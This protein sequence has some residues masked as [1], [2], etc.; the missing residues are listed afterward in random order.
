MDQV[1]SI[2]WALQLSAAQCLAGGDED[3]KHIFSVNLIRPVVNTEKEI[4]DWVAGRGP[5]LDV[6]IVRENYGGFLFPWQ[7]QAT[8]W[9]LYKKVEGAQPWSYV[10]EVDLKSGLSREPIGDD[11]DIVRS[12]V[13]AEIEAKTEKSTRPFSAHPDDLK[14]DPTTGLRLSSLVLEIGPLTHQTAPVSNAILKLAGFVAVEGCD[15]GC[16]YVVFPEFI[17]NR[18]EAKI[19]VKPKEKEVPTDKH[20]GVWLEYEVTDQ[21]SGSAPADFPDTVI[22]IARSATAGTDP[23]FGDKAAAKARTD[24]SHPWRMAATLASAARLYSP[25]RVLANVVLQGLAI[26]GARAGNLLNCSDDVDS[27]DCRSIWR[28]RIAAML[29]MGWERKRKRLAAGVDSEEEVDQHVF[30][31]FASDSLLCAVFKKGE[32]SGSWNDVLD[33]DPFGKKGRKTFGDP[34]FFQEFQEFLTGSGESLQQLGLFSAF[35]DW[36]LERGIGVGHP[37]E[38]WLSQLASDETKPYEFLQS[39]AQ[40]VVAFTDDEARLDLQ[41]CWFAFLTKRFASFEQG[42]KNHRAIRM[43]VASLVKGCNE[44]LSWS[45]VLGTVQRSTYYDDSSCP[46]PMESLLAYGRGKSEEIACL[47]TWLQNAARAKLDLPD[48]I[49]GGSVPFKPN[50]KID[51]EASDRVGAL[52]R[53]IDQSNPDRPKPK[54]S[55]LQLRIDAGHADDGPAKED[56][57]LRGYAIAL[58][59]GIQYLDG[60]TKKYKWDDTRANWI[61]HT[62][63]RIDEIG[64][65]AGGA[66]YIRYNDDGKEELL[67]SSSPVGSTMSQG[68][69]LIEVPYDGLPIASLPERDGKVINLGGKHARDFDGK[70]AYDYRWVLPG[71]KLPLLGYGLVTWRQSTAIENAG[72]VCNEHCRGDGIA[73]LRPVGETHKGWDDVTPGGDGKPYLSLQLPGAPE[74]WNTDEEALKASIDQFDQTRAAT[75]LAEQSEAIGERLRSGTLAEGE[76][77]AVDKPSV[78]LINPG[79]EGYLSDLPDEHKFGV[80]APHCDAQFIQRWLNTDQLIL[81]YFGSDAAFR[82]ALLSHDAL[83]SFSASELET[84]VSDLVESYQNDKDDV[85][86]NELAIGFHPAVTALGLEVGLEGAGPPEYRVLRHKP[87][88]DKESG[89]KEGWVI[90]VTCGSSFAVPNETTLTGKSIK[91]EIPAGKFARVR[92][93]TLIEQKFFGGST[94]AS[95][96]DAKVGVDLNVQAAN[97][98]SERIEGVKYQAFGPLEYWFEVLPDTLPQDWLLEDDNLEVDTPETYRPYEAQLRLAAGPFDATWVR[99][100]EVE[101]HPAHWN[102]VPIRPPLRCNEVK[103]WLPLY[104]GTE[105]RV[106]EKVVKLVTDLRADGFLARERQSIG[107]PRKL[108]EQRPAGYVAYAARPVI[109]FQEWLDPERSKVRQLQSQTCLVGGLEQGICHFSP[110]KRMPVPVLKYA[111]PLTATYEAKGDDDLAGDSLPR[112]AGNGHLLVFDDSGIDPGAQEVYGGLGVHFEVDVLETRAVR[113]EAAEDVNDGTGERAETKYLQL[114]ELGLNPIHHRQQDLDEQMQVRIKSSALF[115]LTHDLVTNAKPAQTAI[116]ASITNSAYSCELADGGTDTEGNWYL[117]KIRVRRMLLPEAQLYGGLEKEK[118][119][120]DYRLPLRNAGGVLVPTDFALEFDSLDIDSVVTVNLAGGSYKFD[121]QNPDKLDTSRYLVSWHHGRF[122]KGRFSWRPQVLQ[123]RYDE[124]GREWITCNKAAPSHDWNIDDATTLKPASYRNEDVFMI[125]LAVNDKSSSLNCAQLVHLSDYSAPFWASFIGMFGR[126]K[127]G[128][129]DQY[130][131]RLS[132]QSLELIGEHLPK[133]SS[134]RCCVEALRKNLSSETAVEDFNPSFQLLHIFRP[135][136]YVDQGGVDTTGGEQVGVF[137]PMENDDC[138]AVP[139]FLNLETSGENID[140]RGCYAYLVS[141]QVASALS[142]SGNGSSELGRLSRIFNESEKPRNDSRWQDLLDEIFPSQDR[143]TPVNKKTPVESL[144][145][146]LPEILGS[147]RIVSD[148]Y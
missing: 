45:N 79:A 89:H 119:S 116:I 1:D 101:T 81:E 82:D 43:F 102:G 121:L 129:A 19:E 104:A 38:L 88:L 57:Y 29:G 53:A 136:V 66:R 5:K 83:S 145:R 141:Y 13:T 77:F 91:V 48:N 137:R 138:S 117:A 51:E 27:K 95:R 131:L 68:R 84:F 111:A 115:G 20:G 146:P 9:H 52:I 6:K 11:A 96:Y 100:I 18:D 80:N 10:D 127:L 120:N 26:T 144:I 65:G 47:K 112:R 114:A 21:D 54:D 93:Y 94:S 31:A 8:K 59:T 99:A 110:V 69:R 28:A 7:W 44:R 4:K 74:V 148:Q 75:W 62:A 15:E 42:E 97:G 40:L 132:G 50:E 143:K 46:N 64:E 32:C 125:S 122:D 33:V 55:G 61:T 22:F 36:R 107:R 126:S 98:F 24:V 25:D 85:P 130:E 90:E 123:Q 140:L 87:F 147:I 56:R 139:T 49:G 135:V 41:I 30:E 78:Y 142:V 105:T 2:G 113:C 63:V 118:E 92:V 72:G 60:E 134:P 73:E 108:G 58:A 14:K 106:D 37:F 39:W 12:R 16:E 133:V 17:F 109:R 86:L 34:G 70:G 35:A 103:Q 23:A 124:P 128:R 3:T 76:D 71:E 67:L